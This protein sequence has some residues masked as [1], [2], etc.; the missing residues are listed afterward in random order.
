[1]L[2][3]LWSS[4]SPLSV[5][6]VLAHIKRRP[7]LAYTTVLTV[8]DRLHEKEVVDREKQGKAFVYRPRVSREA[9]LGEQAAQVLTAAKAP[10]TEAVLLAFLDTAERADPALLDHLSALIAER[11]RGR[12]T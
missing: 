12:A 2:D 10:P 6:E 4:R 3:A 11:R 5:R 8:L 1:V 7:A 9:W